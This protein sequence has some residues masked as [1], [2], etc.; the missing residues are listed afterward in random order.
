M[1]RIAIINP[2]S[3]KTYHGLEYALPV[4]GKKCGV[5]VASLPLLAALTPPE[6]RVNLI[7]EN[8]E[9][10]DYDALSEFDIV[11]VTGLSVQRVR[12]REILEALKKRDLFTVV[13]GAWVTVSEDNFDGLADVIFVGESEETW[14]QF[15]EDWK[16]GKHDICYTQVGPTD[17]TKAPTP[18]LDMMKMHR[19]M[20]GNVQFS[21]GCPFKCEFCE[22]ILIHGRRQ[23]MKTSE[24]VTAELDAFANA[25]VRVVL[26]CD[27]NLIGNKTAAKSLL[28]EIAKWQWSRGYPIRFYGQLSLNLAEDDELMRLMIEANFIYILIG[29]ESSNEE[30]L[31]E[32]KKFHNL[33]KESSMIERVRKIQDAGLE[34]LGHMI[35]GF[36]HDDV[37]IFDRHLK[38]V[39]DAG[40]ADVS[41]A[42]LHAT[43]KTPLYKRLKE[44]GRLDLNEQPDFGTNVIPARMTRA[45]LRDG[46]IRLYKA[47]YEPDAYFERF[48]KFLLNP[49]FKL[50][51]SR[52]RYFREKPLARIKARFIL[53]LLFILTRRRL[54]RHVKDDRLKEE[55]NRRIRRIQKK[56][57]DPG[58]WFVYTVKCIFHYHYY[59]MSRQMDSTP[60]QWLTPSV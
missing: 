53:R 7:D 50:P 49:N 5:Q 45:E 18:R 56:R 41:V 6:H 52:L 43:P 32:I 19:Y 33:G 54:M 20:I 47:L 9:E 51:V 23:R 59:T 22:I 17:I 27:D 35:A 57:R 38:L 26:V 11:G 37:A 39:Q 31:R 16:N 44:E 1:A 48:D 21:R 60:S 34:I 24:Q 55:Y 40:I 36:D 25:K 30:S 2:R 4:F 46:C 13:G 58:I 8:V 12:M 3:E 14:P 28:R 42:M 29:I 10:I 15:L